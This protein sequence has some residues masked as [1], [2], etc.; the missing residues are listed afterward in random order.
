MR[1]IRQNSEYE[2]VKFGVKGNLLL[3]LGQ[4]VAGLATGNKGFLVEAA[5]QEADAASLEAK[6]RVM[7]GNK[8]P[9]KARRLRRTAAGV[10]MLGGGIGVVGGI[11]NMIEGER[12]D[13]SAAAITTAFIGAGV[14][15]EIARR[16]HN[17][18]HN[19]NH[20]HEVHHDA[21]QAGASVDSFLHIVT[22]MGTGVVY[23]SSLAL[24]HRVPGIS[25]LAL[26]ANGFVSSGVAL[27]TL[28]RINHDHRTFDESV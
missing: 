23:A 10:L 13:S 21:H 5:H 7:T 3:G 1:K 20:Q 11:N 4:L 6:A 2:A 15:I 25:N 14:N 19:H 16:S 27:E 24:E 18:R 8:S 26:I 9:K 12:E 28:R 17:G 22:D